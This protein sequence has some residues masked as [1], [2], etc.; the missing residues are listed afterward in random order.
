METLVKIKK[1]M[2]VE[3][4]PYTK[5]DGT[6]AEFIS[7][8]FVLDNGLDTFCCELTGEQAL[9]EVDSIQPNEWHVA[10]IH[11]TVRTYQDRDGKTRYMQSME[12]RGISRE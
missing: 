10:R 11:C 9:Q 7:R 1:I 12:L 6:S 2:G 4:R 5:K 8:T 3:R